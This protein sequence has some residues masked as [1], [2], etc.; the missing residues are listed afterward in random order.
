[1][2][3]VFAID[4]DTVVKLDRVG[5]NGGA[6][7]ESVI[8]RELASCGLPAPGVIDMVVIEGRHGLVMQRLHG[9]LLSDLIRARNGLAD[10][11]ESFV[12]LHASIST[13][14]ISTAPDLVQRLAKQIERSGLPVVTRTELIQ[15]MRGYA[16]DVGLCHFDFHP[17]NVVVT[18]SGWKV[19]DWEAAGSG[20]PV[21][22]F[23]R[24][25]L[26][27][28]DATDDRTVE[29]MRH[30]RAC[31]ISRRGVDH[32]L[33]NVWTRTLAAARLAEGFDGEYSSRL[34]AIAL[35]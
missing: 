7:H 26:L 9:P 31:G 32:D 14:V 22:D 24:S 11:A 1:M 15:H 23:V 8:L 6:E 34:A 33:I 5:F 25:L 17:D 16:G 28:A 2:A 13:Q 27:R 18:E 20:P 3:E 19:I 35:G 30:V 12:E 4:R 10:L 29:F 21:A